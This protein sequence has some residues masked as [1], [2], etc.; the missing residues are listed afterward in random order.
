MKIEIF[1]I[2]VAELVLRT[3]TSGDFNEPGTD[4]NSKTPRWLD[5]IKI[6]ADIGSQA[7]HPLSFLNN[8]GQQLAKI[9]IIIRIRVYLTLPVLWSEVQ[10]MP[11]IF[12][13]LLRGALVKT[14]Q[15]A[16]PK[17]VLSGFFSAEMIR[18]PAR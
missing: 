10:K 11:L 13:P 15:N 2:G 7:Q 6:L 5:P 17:M 9:A 16:S 1:K 3:P 8:E 14:V 4:F 18:E 12:A